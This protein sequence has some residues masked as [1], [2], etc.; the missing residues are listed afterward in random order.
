MIDPGLEG[1]VVLVTGA[2]HGIGEAT[3]RTLATQGARVFATY[4]RPSCPASTEELSKATES[5]VGGPLLYWARQR[6]SADHLVRAVLEN[7][8]AAVAT[9]IDLGRPE[10]ISAIFDACTAAFGPVDVLVNNHTHSAKDTFDPAAVK[11]EG[12]G[13]DYFSTGVADEHFAVNASSYA[14]MMAEYIRRHVERGADWGRI[15]NISTDGAHAHASSVSYAATKH[16]IESY[17]RSAA[18]EV[19]KYGIT[20]NIVAPGPTQTGWLTAEQEVSIAAN[21]PL[22]RCGMPQDVADVV[23]FLASNQAHWLTGQLLYAGGGWRM[24]Q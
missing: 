20:V 14:L 3:A 24:H 23:V 16:A 17:S 7:G 2:N 13:V 12:F 4:F 1:K 5:E 11:T 22:G 6:Q 9:E 15:I 10:N 19:A 8:G 18:L 21:T